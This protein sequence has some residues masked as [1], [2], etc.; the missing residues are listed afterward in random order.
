MSA[1]KS[2]INQSDKCDRNDIGWERARTKEL[3]DWKRHY[4]SIVY[5][6]YSTDK[7]TLNSQWTVLNSGWKHL[8]EDYR[9]FSVVSGGSIYCS[10]SFGWFSEIV[11]TFRESVKMA[12]ERR[13][14]CNAAKVW[15]VSITQNSRCCGLKGFRLFREG[16][17]CFRVGSSAFHDFSSGAENA[18]AGQGQNSKS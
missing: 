4:W 2:L 13:V 5:L 3:K 6:V 14:A 8:T 11:V 18:I 12:A 17:R 9:T 1:N 10:F 15:K 16:A 7:I